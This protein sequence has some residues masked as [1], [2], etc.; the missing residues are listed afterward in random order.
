MLLHSLRA[1]DRMASILASVT[2]TEYCRKLSFCS[3]RSEA[4]TIQVCALGARSETD[5]FR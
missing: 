2:G 3:V 4:E 5:T 1:W